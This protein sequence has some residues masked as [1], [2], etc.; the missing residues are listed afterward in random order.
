MCIKNGEKYL[1]EQIES[2]LNQDFENWELIIID[3]CSKDNSFKIAQKYQKSDSR[4]FIKKNL[5]NL[6]VKYNFL[7]N[8]LSSKCEWIVFCDQD[9]IW[10]LNKLS[11]LYSCI[12]KNIGYSLFVHNGTYLVSEKDQLFKGAFGE[13]V[14]NG[15]KV[16]KKV[17]NRKLF[18]LIKTNQL[19]GCFMCVNKK[20]L[21][22]F[23]T[24]IPLADI[25]HDHW[26][27][28]VSSLYSKTF[29]INKNLIRYRRHEKTN[30]R[31]IKLLKKIF[32][33][34]LIIYSLILNHINLTMGRTL[35]LRKHTEKKI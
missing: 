8:S 5:T 14:R 11:C 20:F 7:L 15:Q 29:F 21:E 1:N 33:R 19:I 26:I 25:Y 18:N 30:T 32:D 24:L 23:I 27:A 2:I 31:K 22:N 35:D 34:F 16:Y 3:D 17:P 4:I 9:D 12:K 13:L 28:I 10:S 6:G